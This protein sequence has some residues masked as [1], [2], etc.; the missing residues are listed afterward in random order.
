MTMSAASR[1]LHRLRHTRIENK[2]LK[3]L[4]LALAILL[5]FVSRQPI[6]DLRVVG[7]P[8]E[9]RGL[10]PGVE[11]GG[12]TEK[13][14]SVRLSGPRNTVRSLTPN[15][16]LVIA[17]LS[18][19]EPGEKVVQLRADESSLPDN[20]KVL[21][22]EPASIRIKLEPTAIKRVKVTAEFTGRLAEGREIY[23]VKLD[24]GEVEIQGPQSLVNK[25]DSVTTEPVNI[26]G[27]QADF[28]RSVE[29]EVMQD[30][31]RVN[32][33]GQIK[34]SVNIGERRATRR[35]S[36]VHVQWPDKNANERLLTKSVEVEVFGPKSAVEKLTAS[37]LRVEINTAG[38]PPN[39]NSV[40]PNVQLPANIEVKNTIPREVKVKR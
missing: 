16:L 36:N 27:Y 3:A 38:L 19:K 15:Q 14:V 26:D 17:D 4:S 37:N 7:V 21:Q 10:S 23:R 8:I 1:L 24:P 32:T 2:G 5:F 13:T 9:Y 28:Q 12:D 40:I 25:T 39:A 20:V 35:F 33:Q 29:V 34:L 22:I 18:N 6:T 30:S 31:L 11:L